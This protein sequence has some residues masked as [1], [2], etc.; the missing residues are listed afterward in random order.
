MHSASPKPPYR[1]LTRRVAQYFGC[2]Y[3]SDGTPRIQHDA[4]VLPASELRRIH[5]AAGRLAAVYDELAALVVRSPELLDYFELSP[6]QRMMWHTSGGAWRG[7][8]RADVFLTRDGRVQICEVNTD[9]PGGVPDAVL[10]NA[11]VRDSVRGDDP[12]AVLQSLFTRWI[13]R[14]AGDPKRIGIVFPP[15]LGEDMAIIMLYRDWLLG[16]GARVT[17]GG[18]SNLHPM[19]TGVGLLGEPIDFMFRHYKTDEFATMRNPYLLNPDVA[20][21]EPPAAQTRVT[22]EHHLVMLL[23]AVADKTLTVLNPFGTIVTQSKLSLA[24][25]WD[26]LERFSP[27][28]QRTIRD[29]VPETRKITAVG[30]DVLLR[31]QASW[32]LKS[33][34]GFE[35]QEAICGVFATADR[36]QRLLTCIDHSY[37]VAQRFFDIEPD[38]Q[39]MLPNYGAFII[40]GEP[41]GCLYR[42][43]SRETNMSAICA[44]VFTAIE[45]T[46]ERPAISAAPCS[47]TLQLGTW[48]AA[49]AETMLDV[50]HPYGTKWEPFAHTNVV[51]PL[52]YPG[53]EAPVPHVPQRALDCYG[54]GE[55]NAQLLREDPAADDILFW[56]DLPGEDA[57]A[58]A[59]AIAG[60]HT[61]II[62]IDTFYHQRGTVDFAPVLSAM[63]YYAPRLKGIVRSPNGPGAI[64]QDARRLIHREHEIDLVYNSYIGLIPSATA[65]VRLGVRRIRAIYPGTVPTQHTG[66]LGLILEGFE[67]EFAEE[68]CNALMFVPPPR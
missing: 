1:E 30:R 60:T 57:I 49:P 4:V 9:T 13:A 11:A 64:I 54:W 3:M 58:F 39:G 10:F 22:F 2:L 42:A 48:A 16:L 40:D 37:W 51:M 12:N 59:A 25:M 47:T 14:A 32:V 27:D 15:E 28:S 23:R 67:P 34:Y 62:G 19:G 53:V 38:A 18:P 35:G 61:P 21:D 36:W 46:S 43:S 68:L 63:A 26:M 50:W 8:A 45:A 56:I 24:F 44:P 17:M 6:A 20:V 33:P 7:V 55:Q 52:F 66:P 5:D 31:E 65:L 29:Y 41:A